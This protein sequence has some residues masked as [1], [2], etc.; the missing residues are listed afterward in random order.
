MILL[1]GVGR[2]YGRH[3]AVE[4]LDLR[5]EAGELVGLLGPNGAGK[6]TTLRMIA[7]SLAP[8]E[9]SVQVAGFDQEAQPQEARAAV[10]YLPER[11]PV[12]D[13]LTVREQVA[14]AA[15]LHGVG[16]AAAVDAALTR[17]SLAAVAGRRIGH[18]SKGF[19]QRVG[20][21][22]ALVHGP[23]VLVL[24][25][26]TS[27]LDP[28]QRAELRALLASL[29]GE[30][31][32]VLLSTHV[33]SDVEAICRRAVVIAAGRV[34]LDVPVGQAADVVVTVAHPD[35]LA[36][37]LAALPGVRVVEA[38]GPATFRVQGDGDLRAAVARAAVDH[39]LLALDLH[40]DLEAA[41]LRATEA[42]R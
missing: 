20:L 23:R 6:T 42:V 31:T 36:A 9:G 19:R 7:G 34:V 37:T 27:G 32:T 4:P 33:L 35:G 39:D 40:H 29:A 8:S 17:C 12:H 15:R 10:G 38:L 13:D 22:C 14:F 21:A 1:R 3:R 30:G 11:P 18:L 5:V 25:E 26:P 16:D 28:T 2:S 41:F 24:D